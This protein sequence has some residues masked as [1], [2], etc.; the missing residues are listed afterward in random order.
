MSDTMFASVEAQQ[1]VHELPF[2]TETKRGVDFWTGVEASGDI[3]ADIALGEQCAGICLALAS[4]FELPLLIA[5]V[6][7]DMT[8]AG[9]FTAVEA[10]FIASI[11][12][13]ARV[14]SYD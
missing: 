12:S 7:R 11:A 1:A 2:V 8:L 10:G 5:M 9:K 14:G 13:A 3:T 4:R 6:L